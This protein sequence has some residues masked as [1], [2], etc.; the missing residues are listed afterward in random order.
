MRGGSRGVQDFVQNALASSLGGTPLGAMNFGG[1]RHNRNGRLFR[2]LAYAAG[3][4][5]REYTGQTPAP[6][7]APSQDILGL[8]GLVNGLLGSDGLVAHLLEGVGNVV[9]VLPQGL[10]KTLEAV[11]EIAENVTS[12]VFDLLHVPKVDLSKLSKEERLIPAVQPLPDWW[13]Q[14]NNLNATYAAQLHSQ[15]HD[16]IEGFN[17][18]PG[19]VSPAVVHYAAMK[20]GD[21][22][23]SK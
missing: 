13:C 23:G 22:A 5:A 1:H 14:K 12:D 18:I 11:G 9:S 16:I 15:V 7:A 4:S 10:T 19:Y 2:R 6:A 21:K 8:G 3:L 17:R 20:Y